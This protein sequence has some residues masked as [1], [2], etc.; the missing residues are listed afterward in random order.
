M[1]RTNFV[2]IE[3]SL[4]YWPNKQFRQNRSNACIVET[5]G[6]DSLNDDNRTRTYTKSRTFYLEKQKMGRELNKFK[7]LSTKEIE[8]ANVSKS[9]IRYSS[10]EHIKINENEIQCKQ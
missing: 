4:H 1:L 8:N 7:W 6:F 5:D 9:F 2:F 3:Y 10:S